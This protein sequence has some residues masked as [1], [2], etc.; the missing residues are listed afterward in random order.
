MRMGKKLGT[1]PLKVRTE[2]G[3]L[4]LRFAQGQNREWTLP[5]TDDVSAIIEIRKE[6]LDFASKSGATVG[7]LN[8][9]RK[10][11][12]SAGYRIKGKPR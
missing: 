11:I 8:A 9:I 3:V 12:A 1:N 2:G 7:Q 5:K 6:A 10:A 4:S